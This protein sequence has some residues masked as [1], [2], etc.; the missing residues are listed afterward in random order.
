MA[1]RFH[2]LI[3]YMTWHLIGPN[4]SITHH[5]CMKTVRF[6]SQEY[7]FS[8]KIIIYTQIFPVC[9]QIKLNSQLVLPFWLEVDGRITSN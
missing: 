1:V 9:L 3:M 2:W 4:N 6:E 7:T 8:D 5:L